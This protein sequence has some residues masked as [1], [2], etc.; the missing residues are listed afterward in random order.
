MPRWAH[1]LAH[2]SLAWLRPYQAE[3]RITIARLYRCLV[4]VGSRL[5]GGPMLA[6]APLRSGRRSSYSARGSMTYLT[7]SPAVRYD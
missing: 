2:D 7:C 6:L 5:E 3:E 4:L 1:H